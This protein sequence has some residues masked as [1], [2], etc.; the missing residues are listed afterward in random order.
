MNLTL[1]SGTRLDFRLLVWH[2]NPKNGH[3][4]MGLILHGQIFFEI[5]F[6]ELYKRIHWILHI[7]QIHQELVYLAL[8][9]TH[10]TKKSRTI[11]TD[12]NLTC[13]NSCDLVI[14]GLI[15]TVK[16]Q[17]SGFSSFHLKN[18]VFRWNEVWLFIWPMIIYDFRAIYTY[19][20][21]PNT[22]NTNFAHPNFL[23]SRICH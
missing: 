16:W 5:F 11:F 2:Q 3:K 18:W 10:T 15:G 22:A 23:V 1:F 21:M 7:Y 12:Y 4:S 14:W 20:I 13:T 17:E 6:I 19:H 8:V 9:R